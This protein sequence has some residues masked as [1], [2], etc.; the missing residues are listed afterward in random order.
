MNFPSQP[1]RNP[2]HRADQ[3]AA[4]AVLTISLAVMGGQWLLSQFQQQETL[5]LTTADP[6]PVLQRLA[7]PAELAPVTSPSAEPREMLVEFVEKAPPDS[8]PPRLQV[9]IN[10]APWQELTLLP[11]VGETLARR[12]VAWREEEGPFQTINDLDRV[13]GIGPKTLHNMRPFVLPL[14]K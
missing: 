12:I 2:F 10:R 5:R 4:A 7:A 9:D 13:R 6:A 14:E 8:A 1:S 11:G 3:A